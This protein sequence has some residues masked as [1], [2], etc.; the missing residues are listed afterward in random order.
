VTVPTV[1]R[2]DWTALRW[3]IDTD[4]LTPS[5]R[6]TDGLGIRSRNCFA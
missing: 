5:T 2:L 1:E 6:S 4:G 3:S